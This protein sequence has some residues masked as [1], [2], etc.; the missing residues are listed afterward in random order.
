MSQLQA[1]KERRSEA[2]RDG[3]LGARVG[4]IVYIRDGRCVGPAR[5]QGRK[6]GALPR[7]A[8]IE[9]NEAADEAP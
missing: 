4:R 7:P 8:R 2:G 1:S 9:F 5:P 3:S 6:R